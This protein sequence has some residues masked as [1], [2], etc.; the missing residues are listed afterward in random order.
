MKKKIYVLLLAAGIITVIFV[1]AGSN[2]SE[3]TS[4]KRPGYG[5]EE[6][7]YSLTVKTDD[8]EYEMELDISPV[9]IPDEQLQQAFDDAYEIVCGEIAGD[10]E[11]LDC[12]TD[13]LNFIDTVQKY[14]MSV[15]YSMDDYS[16][17]DVGGHVTL[18]EKITE[19][20]Q[21]DIHVKITYEEYSQTYII[22]VTITRPEKNDSELFME[23]IKEEIEHIDENNAQ[24]E[25]INL[26]QEIDGKKIQFI[27]K[28]NSKV[29][30]VILI[31]F[32]GFMVGYYKKF[33]L[34][35]KQQQQ[36][37]KQL[38]LDYS[39]IVSK[40]SLLMGAGMS[41]VAALNKITSDYREAKMP[42]RYAYEEIA[43][44]CNKIAAGISESDAYMELGRACRLHSYIKLAGLLSQN[45]RKGG[46]GFTKILKA[47]VTEAFQERKALA[48]QAGEEAATKLLLP[49]IMM[50]AIV[51][52][53]IIVPAFMS[54]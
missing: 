20:V 7:K 4:L 53:V 40:L 24:D 9:K 19:S 48:K 39:E 38:Q 41:G 43:V 25:E 46:E 27:E 23:K 30:L 51:L 26:P 10:N 44:T 37:E 14:G 35:K 32:A 52:V 8:E 17:V 18:D 2:T 36:K 29:V 6:T 42:K 3:V 13:D 54:F 47:E 1:A 45:I 22:P 16:V 11:S 50:L 33:T 31:I 12:V 15:E 28:D 34:V 21:L 49:M 5:Q